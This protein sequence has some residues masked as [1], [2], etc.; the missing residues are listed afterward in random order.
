MEQVKVASLASA[1][2]AGFKPDQGSLVTATSQ[3]SQGVFASYQG[4]LVLAEATEAREYPFIVDGHPFPA[5]LVYPKT[6]DFEWRSGKYDVYSDGTIV[7]RGN[8]EVW[9]RDQVVAFFNAGNKAAGN[10]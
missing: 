10:A 7:A 5:D 3:I 1:L 8:G 4:R 6:G 9:D 2:K